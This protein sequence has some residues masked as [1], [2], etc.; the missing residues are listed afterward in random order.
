[1]E[2]EK[3]PPLADTI[4]IVDRARPGHIIRTIGYLW[5]KVEEELQ[6]YYA[7]KNQRGWMQEVQRMPEVQMRQE[8]KK[9]HKDPKKKT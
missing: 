2:F 8:A 1:M 7:K 5:V 9:D 4:K 3:W 6:I